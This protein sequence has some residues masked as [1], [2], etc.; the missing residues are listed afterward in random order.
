MPLPARSVSRPSA[1]SRR[2]IQL[3]AATVLGTLIVLLLAGTLLL[4]LYEAHHQGPARWARP[5]ETEVSRV[6]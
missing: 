4:G 6:P 2:G 3:A 5:V 1:L